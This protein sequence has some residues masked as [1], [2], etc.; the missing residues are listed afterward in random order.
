MDDVTPFFSIVIPLYNKETHIADTLLSVF[1]QSFQD[2]EVII[3]NDGSTD[4]SLAIA[5]TFYD[6]RIKIFSIANGGVSAARNYGVGHAQ[7]AFIAFLDA[8]DTW[9][10]SFL[11]EMKHLIERYPACG[12]YSSSYT[13]LEQ[14]KVYDKCRHLPEGFV[15]NYFETEFK[16][17][18]SRLSATV[19]RKAV[20]DATGGFPAGMVSGEDSYFCARVALKYAM[21]FTPKL[22]VTYNKRFSGINLRYC[23]A[24]SCRESWFDLYEEGDFYRNELLADKAIRAGIRYALGFH[25]SRSILIEKRTEFT[26]L[27]KKR[28][29]YLFILNRLPYPGIVLLKRAKYIYSLTKLLNSWVSM[30]TPLYTVPNMSKMKQRWQARAAS[31]LHVCKE[32]LIN[33][34]RQ[35]GQF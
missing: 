1:N 4:R 16:H 26:M 3:V 31:V 13:V 2:Y 30:T 10:P 34:A 25:K 32:L 22:L 20:F 17:G 9:E 15:Q 21:A 5:E 11:E 18:I 14:N 12:L 24:D 27:S 6:T 19:V 35:D 7:S 29:R 23:Q 33:S 8:D 28:W